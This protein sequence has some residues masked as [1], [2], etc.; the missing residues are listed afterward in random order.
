MTKPTKCLTVDDHPTVKQGLSLMF[1]DTP[2]LEL[3]GHVQNGEEVV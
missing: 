2:D 1:G 3:V